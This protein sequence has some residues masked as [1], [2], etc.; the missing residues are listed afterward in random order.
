MSKKIAWHAA[1]CFLFGFLFISISWVGLPADFNADHLA[2][3]YRGTHA[4]SYWDL[5]RLTLDPRTP[6]WFYPANGLMEYLRPF[7][8]L[9]MKVFFDLFQDSMIP[10][11]L[12][13]AF[14][15]GL[16]SAVFFLLVF[17]STAS[18]L[19]G[20]LAV[21][22]YASFPSNYFMLT[23]TF[24]VDF[25]YFVSILS[26]IALLT[27]VRLSRGDFKKSGVFTASVF[28]WI[29][30]IW[31]A[32]KLKSSEKILPF[33]C[34]AFLG[35]TSLRTRP[36]LPLTRIAFLA[37][38]IACMMVL[39]IPAR[40]LAKWTKQPW[41][42]A[43]T[44]GS[45]TPSTNIP[46]ALTPKDKTTFGFHWKNLLQ[47]TFYVPGGDF[48]FTSLKRK[49]WPRSFSENLGFFLAWFFW[50][51]LTFIIFRKISSED[52]P[53]DHDFLIVAIWFCVILAGFANGLTVYDT[54]FLNF[55]YI[56]GVLLLFYGTHEIE[57]IFFKQD[58]SRLVFRGLI[59]A[60]VLYT[61]ITNF[62]FYSKLLM[63][64][65]GMQNTLIKSETDIF[66]ETFGRDP[67]PWELYQKHQEM[68][69]RFEVIDWYEL[70][71]DWMDTAKGKL[72]KEKMI[73]FFTR[74]TDSERLKALQNTGYSA[75]LWRQY[76]FLD[77]KPGIFKA[78]K[79]IRSLKKKIRGKV[80]KHEIFI[81]R[82]RHL[83]AENPAALPSLP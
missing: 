42:T 43:N 70:P 61:A 26:L 69:S 59:F 21:I 58:K 35:W 37:G 5:V 32:I 65:G 54:R 16:L 76:D 51:G 8:F 18:I 30:S 34:L 62:G 23:S 75:E 81:Y 74:T 53:K 2:I 33:I 77:A 44:P 10:F 72:E 19:Y 20:W 57:D 67:G 46:E 14:G 11:H 39:V 36:R 56:P 83:P 79:L 25:Q 3:N 40:S 49:E 13:A 31:L 82:I 48:P 24:S 55:A 66:R 41:I 7:Q 68:E 47:R 6:A 28:L 50:L 73:Y 17:Y 64:F 12:T 22:L 15:F 80:K 45:Q 52:S 1:G 38:I 63:H 60:A 29:V 4:L 27:F 78:A 9:I 71:S